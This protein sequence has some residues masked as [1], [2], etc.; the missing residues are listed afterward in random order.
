MDTIRWQIFQERFSCLPCYM[1]RSLWSDR[2]SRISIHTQM[3][4]KELR[5]ASTW[6][7]GDLAGKP[8][9]EPL[10]CK[11]APLSGRNAAKGLLKHPIFCEVEHSAICDA[12]SIFEWSHLEIPSSFPPTHTSPAYTF[13]SYHCFFSQ[14]SP[15]FLQALIYYCSQYAFFPLPPSPFLIVMLENLP[16]TPSA[17]DDEFVDITAAI[18]EEVDVPPEEDPEPF[19]ISWKPASEPWQRE[20][21][22]TFS[23]SFS[24]RKACV[25]IMNITVVG[26]S[27][28][29]SR[30]SLEAI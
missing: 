4:P 6:S 20:F 26:N 22:Y 5:R 23:K 28:S 24:E 11:S 21:W 16:H 30:W 7:L 15:A 12:P 2:R 1:G 10:C 29:R 27:D 17:S 13:A 3:S 25:Y 9:Q 8:Q 14:S 18:F 19:V